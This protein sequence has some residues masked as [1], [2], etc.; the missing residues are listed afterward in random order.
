MHRGK[1]HKG[2]FT[3]V[4]GQGCYFW[5]LNVNKFFRGTMGWMP[6]PNPCGIIDFSK[7]QRRKLRFW[8]HYGDLDYLGDY[9]IEHFM[10]WYQ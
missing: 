4:I 9:F 1:L 10:S 3:E 7:Q 6:V 5:S 8:S 2:F